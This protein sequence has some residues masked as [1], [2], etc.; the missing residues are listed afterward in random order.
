M[1][2]LQFAFD[3]HEKAR[4]DQPHRWVRHCVAY[5]GTHDNNTTVGWFDAL[6]RRGR[7]GPDRLT[8]RERTLRYL[9]SDGKGLHWDLIRLL[10]SSV[11]NTAIV[12]MQDVLGLGAD[13]RMNFPSIP[14]GNWEW[15]MR[16]GAASARLAARLR[17]LAEVTERTG[18]V[19]P[20]EWG[21]AA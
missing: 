12:P 20:A 18:G 19:R 13:A 16:R 15:R 9:G 6:P 11:A 4:Y 8:V 14:Q 5:T 3:G 2:V 10:Y 7:K 21:P 17:E 1:R